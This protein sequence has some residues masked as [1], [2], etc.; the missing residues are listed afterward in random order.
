MHYVKLIFKGLP[1]K[2]YNNLKEKSLL[3]AVRKSIYKYSV[4]M[5]Y[6]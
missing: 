5:L 1:E 6:T 4:S 2:N 3:S